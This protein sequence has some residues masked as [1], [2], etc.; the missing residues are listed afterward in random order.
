MTQPDSISIVYIDRITKK[1]EIEQVYG[2]QAL[3]FLYGDR[4][5]SKTIGK[6]LLKLISRAPLF[7]KLFGFW[8]NQPWTRKNILPFIKKYGVDSS[9]F[10][11]P[12]DSFASFNAFF[13]RKLKP[14]SRPI[15]SGDQIAIIP[16][17][18]RY[19]FYQ[20]IELA[21]GF[22]VKGQKFNIGTLLGDKTL[23]A[24]YAHG[25]MVIARLCPTDY[26]R[27]HFPVDCI[28]SETRLINGC[29]YSVNPIAL[30]QNVQIFTQNKRCITTLETENFGKV[31]FIEV[32]ATSVGSMIQTYKPYQNQ[33]KG[34]EKGYFSFGAS[35]LI[36]LFEPNKIIFDE[37][38]LE[39]TRQ[40]LEIKCL[41]GQ[42]LGVMCSLTSR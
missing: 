25:A 11:E 38:L 19:L 8:Q 13:I 21:D 28:P 42:R 24:N 35:S 33:P 23:A 32:G 20:N 22:V 27:F 1:R 34:S 18:G 5:F 14:E 16:A 7:S 30:K 26:H 9:E 17:D 15:A 40:G 39:A 37:D 41:L 29:L 31:L 36:V 12:V 2:A 10:L 3:Q 4:F 6:P